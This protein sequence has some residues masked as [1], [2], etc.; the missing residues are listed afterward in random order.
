[1]NACFGHHLAIELNKYEA[2]IVLI[3]V[4][5]FSNKFRLWLTGQVLETN[6]F[7]FLKVE[8]IRNQSQNI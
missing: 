2:L 4:T 8:I 1:L 7:R 3:N 5:N 6:K